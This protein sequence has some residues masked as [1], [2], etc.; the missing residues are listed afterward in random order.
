MLRH[1]FQRGRGSQRWTAG[2]GALAERL[3]P[4][5]AT[6]VLAP[7]V[8]LVLV[9]GGASPAVAGSEPACFW[10]TLDGDK[11]RLCPGYDAHG[12]RLWHIVERQPRR[13]AAQHAAHP[14]KVAHAR[15]SSHYHSSKYHR[16]KYHRP[17]YHAPKRHRPKRRHYDDYYDDHYSKDRR[18]RGPRLRPRIGL[19]IDGDG[20]VR[21]GLG[22]GTVIGGIGVGVDFLP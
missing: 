21:V 16:P 9:T 22:V 5:I 7:I 1:C 4:R 11:V 18:Y 3:S 20:D 17:K 10:G 6:V 15:K 12:K 14:P 13:Y 2:L 19:T 8:A